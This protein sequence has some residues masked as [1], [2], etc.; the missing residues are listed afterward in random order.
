MDAPATGIR[1]VPPLLF[2]VALLERLFG[3]EYRQYE[4]RVRRWL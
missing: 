4:A 2:L 1:T 3:E